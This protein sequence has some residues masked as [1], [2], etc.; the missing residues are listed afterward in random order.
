MAQVAVAWVL[1]KEGVTAPIVGTTNL[2]NLKDIISTSY[3]SP[4]SF[5]ILR[6]QGADAQPMPTDGISVK[7]TEEEIK[8]LEEP[9]KSRAIIGH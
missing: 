5:S 4:T 1:S 2:E 9:Y 8:H 6:C 7:L 3:A